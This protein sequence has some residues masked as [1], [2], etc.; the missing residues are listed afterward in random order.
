M[1]IAT[2][3]S[4]QLINQD[5]G[6]VE[7]YT[8]PRIVEA[9][10]RTMGAI[11][12]DP[13]SSATANQRVGAARFYTEVD[14]GLAQPWEGRIW[15][16]HPFG[17]TTNG[18]WVRKIESEFMRGGSDRHVASPSP[19][20][21]SCGSSRCS[22]ARSASS[23]RAPITFCLTGRSSEASPRGAWSR[24]TGQTSTRSHASSRRWVSSSFPI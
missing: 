15:M 23:R 11:D 17:R 4:H 24:T 9:A 2:P 8:P 19:R 16:N 12:L 1:T 5:S 14:D 21:L 20:R 10:R 7:Y 6:D 3:T 18:P 13:A 22:A